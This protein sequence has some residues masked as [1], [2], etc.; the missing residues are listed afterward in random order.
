MEKETQRVTMNRRQFLGVAGISMG[1]VL[2]GPK[3]STA[4]KGTTDKPNMVFFY[5]DTHRWGAMNFTQTPAVHTPFMA[6][7]KN[8]GVSLD[9]CYST[10]PI[11]SPY[12]GILMSG[13]WPWEQGMMANH[14]RLDDR[15]DRTDTFRGTLAWM[16]KDAGY[17]TGYFG[18]SHWGG[19]DLRPFGF[20]SCI[21]W[22]KTNNHVQSS[23]R[24]DGGPQQTWTRGSSDE[25]NCTPTV[26]QALDWIDRHHGGPEP[27]FAMISVNPPHGS[28]TDAP[29]SKKALYPNP[30][31]LPFHPHD[32]VHKFDQHQGYHAH[33][34]DVDDDIGRILAKLTTLGIAQNTIF[35]YSS[36]HGGMAGVRGIDYG[37]KRNPE[38]ESTRLPF[39]A[40][41]PG[42]IPAN[43]RLD[44]LFSTI[45]HFPTLCGLANLSKHLAEQ[46]TPAALDSL[47]YLK[48]SPGVDLSRNILGQPGGPDPK[49]IFIMH[50][51][52]MNNHSPH[53]TV[54]RGVVTKQYTYALTPEKE[55]CLYDNT[56]PYQYPNL[57]GQ[58]GY[59]A[60]RREL[61]EEIHNWMKVAEYPYTDRWFAEM[62]VKWIKAWNKEHGLGADNPD[63]QVGK[64]AL[65]HVDDSKGYG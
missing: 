11:C 1:S 54:F 20:D 48:A 41:C 4:A 35:I 15:P 3:T 31:T 34:S 60:V 59:D 40:V 30:E 22:N 19:N 65:F 61:K 29:Q 39:L 42:T 8:N 32:T 9:R 45:D 43:V 49:S 57:L 13:R 26:T 17:A 52:N 46:G 25:S 36:D 53:Q 63:R 21:T 28:M 55:Y 16:F 37:Q 6:H 24:E 7:M 14:M 47:A 44:V 27:F 58:A 50:P 23:F 12:R 18:K 62:P 10:L 2:L 56:G 51:S 38:D 5:S 33:V 64:Q